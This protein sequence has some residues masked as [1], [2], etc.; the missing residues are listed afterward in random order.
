[1]AIPITSPTAIPA[2]VPA[3]VS[4]LTE[5]MTPPMSPWASVPA[6]CASSLAMVSGHPTRYSRY[7]PDRDTKPETVHSSSKRVIDQEHGVA[8]KRMRC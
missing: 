4:T 5:T 6:I 3:P 7:D 2:P 1:M 8:V